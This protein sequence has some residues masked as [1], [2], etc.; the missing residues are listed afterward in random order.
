[1]YIRGFDFCQIIFPLS[2]DCQRAIDNM[3]IRTN[4]P[5]FYLP[6]LLR[7]LPMRHVIFLFVCLVFSVTQSS[8][9]GVILSH[10][11]QTGRTLPA[12]GLFFRDGS[13]ANYN[14]D[15]NSATLVVDGDTGGGGDTFSVFRNSAGLQ[16]SDE[17]I[18][19]VH[20]LG[21]GR[22]L[23]STAGAARLRTAGGG[24][25]EFEDG[26]VIE[27]D[28][29]NDEATMF[30]DGTSIF[31]TAGGALGADE[32]IDAFTILPN[33]NYALS[34]N[35]AARLGATPLD[36]TGRELVEYDPIN[37]VASILISGTG[38]TSIFR[39]NAN[40]D[41]DNAEINAIHALADGTFL[42]AVSD[43]AARLPDGLGGILAFDNSD[44]V[45]WNPATSTATLFFS[46]D[47][48]FDG[49]NT[50]L[51]AIS[52]D[53]VGV[54]EPSTWALLTLAGI[55][56]GGYRVRKRRNKDKSHN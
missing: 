46:G 13:L 12:G 8:F 35:A 10:N 22:V 23:I 7:V 39:N 29:I 27:Y 55:G 31:R 53:S 41:T 14:S 11:N 24:I 2:L 45:H 51:D 28:I 49:G 44:I 30:V 56:F 33:G 32:E 1:M 25:L 4:K 37:D 40:N 16:V 47:S 17:N 9:A 54:P 3:Y 19:A 43:S 52:L 21:N 34:T 38:A 50:N 6:P 26:D 42:L 18:D 5:A 36:F 20:H 15:T 48:L